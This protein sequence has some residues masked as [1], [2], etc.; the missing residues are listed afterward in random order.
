MQQGPLPQHPA[1]GMPAAAAAAEEGRG[2][3]RQV[4]YVDCTAPFLRPG[5]SWQLDRALIPDGIHPGKKRGSGQRG[6]GWVL[7][8]CMR[9][10]LREAEQL[11]SGG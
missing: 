9:R 1:E 11:R 2:G 10:A 6:G 5:S 3:R 7:A 4:L 8:E